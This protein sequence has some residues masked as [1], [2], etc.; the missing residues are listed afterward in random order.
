MRLH[1]EM[2]LKIVAA[3]EERKRKKFLPEAFVVRSSWLNINYFPGN[4]QSRIIAGNNLV[5]HEALAQ[6]HGTRIIERIFF[7]VYFFLSSMNK[8]WKKS[9][10]FILMRQNEFK[11][12]TCAST[13]GRSTEKNHVSSANPFSIRSRTKT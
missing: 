7:L 2:N 12:S 1:W 9:S 4:V 10:S 6:F 5:E 3:N 8:Y 11:F 13:Y